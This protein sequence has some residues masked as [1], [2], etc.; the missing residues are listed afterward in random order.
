MDGNNPNRINQV[1]MT[2]TT[3]RQ[4]PQND[5]G[6]VMA[7]TISTAVQAGTGVAGVLT[8]GNPVL[9]AAVNNIASAVSAVTGTSAAPPGTGAP[10]GTG[11]T[12]GTGKSEW[13]LLEAQQLMRAE[14]RQF[15]AE[16]LKLQNAMQKESRE[17]NAV[18]NIMKV[19]HD[20]AKAA[21]NNI[22]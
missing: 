4:T 17:F 22:R 8:L 18:S 12:G 11:S 2:Q 3:Q 20:S 21:I 19:R 16:Y 15:N 14:E 7:R 1:S 6:T 13:D 10:A 9:S 5:F